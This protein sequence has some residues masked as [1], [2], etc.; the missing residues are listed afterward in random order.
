[1]TLMLLRVISKMLI[2]LFVY[3]LVANGVEEKQ[4]IIPL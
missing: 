2:S 4:T 3:V 1:M